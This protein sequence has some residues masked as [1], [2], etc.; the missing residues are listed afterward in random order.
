MHNHHTNEGAPSASIPEHDDPLTEARA[1][2]ANDTQQRMQACAAE[3]H[4]V[5][6]RHGMRLDVTPAQISIVPT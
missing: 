6:Q 3:I 5:L 2:I 4:E 1:L